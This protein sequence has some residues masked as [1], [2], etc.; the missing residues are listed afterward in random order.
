LKSLALVAYL[1]AAA[2]AVLPVRA[3]DAAG[4]IPGY[5]DP[6]T[7]IFTAAPQPPAPSVPLASAPV[8]V[9]GTIILH[10]TV[11]LDP[12]ITSDAVI[13]ALVTIS[14]Q[15]DTYSSSVSGYADVSRKGRTATVSM[16]LPYEFTLAAA[17][18]SLTIATTIAAPYVPSVPSVTLT[19]IVPLPANGA[20]KTITLQEGL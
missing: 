3:A 15:D 7:H 5:Y 6:R 10:A 8:V 2:L 18:E 14:A 16:T 11:K 1:L 20:T 19:K 12:A 4:L 13:S 9:R 17:N